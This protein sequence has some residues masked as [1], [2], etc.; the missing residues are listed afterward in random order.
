MLWDKSLCF[1][2]RTLVGWP[3]SRRTPLFHPPPLALLLP[4]PV[5]QE[6]HDT[7]PSRFCHKLPE[8]QAQ[9]LLPTEPLRSQGSYLH[10]NTSQPWDP[11]WGS[12]VPYFP[13]LRNWENPS[14][15]FIMLL[16]GQNELTSSIQNS[17]WN[18]TRATEEFYCCHYHYTLSTTST[19]NP[20][21]LHAIRYGALGTM[22][23]KWCGQNCL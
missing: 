23:E 21:L 7:Q 6:T 9:P 11:P 13:H 5:P 14:T 4:L 12:H 8:A 18:V 19:P 2:P 16:W 10:S 3:L 22:E 17:A 15:S 1:F 20:I